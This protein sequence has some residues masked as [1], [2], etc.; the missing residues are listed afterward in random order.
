MSDPII[1]LVAVGLISIACQYFAYRIKLPAILPLLVVGILVGPV[2]GVINA[3]A[4]FGDLLFPI[5]SLSV[6]IILFEG[7]LTLRFGDLAGHGSMVRNLCTIGT[8]VTWL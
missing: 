1:P 6:A 3:D 5:V 7:S 8:L 2:Y 4:L